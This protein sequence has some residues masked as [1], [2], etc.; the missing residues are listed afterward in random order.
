MFTQLDTNTCKILPVDMSIWVHILSKFIPFNMKLLDQVRTE[1]KRRNYSYKTEQSYVRWIVRYVKFHK[2]THPNELEESDIVA[3]LN[4]LA[5]QRN[6]AGSTQNQ[7]LCAIIFLYK[8]VLDRKLADLKDLK[9]AKKKRNI[10]VVLTPGEVNKIIRN[11]NK[12]L[13][14]LVTSLV[15][16]TGMRI[17]EALRLRIKDVDFE[18]HQIAV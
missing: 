7:A 11:I 13:P 2:L 9:W 15:Y 14:R 10:P 4:Y 16:G 1:I 18:Y 5:V 3:F 17:S 12:R 8:A 6:V